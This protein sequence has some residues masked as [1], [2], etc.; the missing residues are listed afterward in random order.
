MMNMSYIALILYLAILQIIFGMKNH[1]QTGLFDF[2]I[3][4]QYAKLLI[5]GLSPY[6]PIITNGIPFNYPPSSFVLFAPLAFLPLKTA[7]L[8][9]TEFSLFFFIIT[10]IVFLKKYFP[11]KTLM[12]ILLVLLLQNFPTKFTLVSG[13]VNLIVLSLLL[14]AFLYDQQNKSGSCGTVLGISCRY[15]VDPSY[16][17]TLLPSKK[18]VPLHSCRIPTD[19]VFKPFFH[20]YFAS[21]CLLS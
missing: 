7:T 2:N 19:S 14:I 11:S 5:S 4:Y 20:G 9:F 18:K 8:I 15:Q 12:C 16:S 6:N 17:D 10:G 3:Y 21:I 13:Q 1:L